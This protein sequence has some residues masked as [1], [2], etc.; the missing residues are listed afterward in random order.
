MLNSVKVIAGN[1]FKELIRDR[2]LLSLAVFSFLLLGST[3]FL[4]S[5]SL[6]QDS[7]IIIDFGLFGIFLFSVIM[8]IFIGGSTI[9]KELDQR[10][11]ITILARP[12]KR[13]WFLL[14]KFF[15]L[16]L[17][18]MVLIILMS[19]VFFLLVGFKTS[20]QT[21]D[22][23]LV[24]A[25]IYIFLEMTVLTALMLLFSS[26]ATTIMSI[27]YGLAFFII[28]HSTTTIVSLIKNTPGQVKYIFIT[29][30]YIFPNF[31]KYNLRNDAVYHLKPESSEILLTLGYTVIFCSLLLFL[32]NLAFKKQ[33]L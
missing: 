22:A 30:Y 10:T 12:I 18:Q 17:T 14:G 31:E 4:G 7:K 8:T 21:I 25:V 29:I 3:I 27:I 9:T 6:D 28:G 13:S 19:A 11:A 32:A 16:C 20:W 33:E 26:F 2:I 5:I 24:L 15:G 1:T 23:A